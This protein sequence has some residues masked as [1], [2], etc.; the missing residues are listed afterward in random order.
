MSQDV[1]GTISEFLLSILV[2]P[3]TKQ[4]V[5]LADATVVE[6]INTEIAEGR[7]RNEGGKQVTVP[8]HGALVREDGLMAYAIRDG[9]PVMLVAEGIPL[10]IS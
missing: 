3:A 4:K 2:C 1:K 6:K 8:L 5:Q 9:I 10:R 7:C